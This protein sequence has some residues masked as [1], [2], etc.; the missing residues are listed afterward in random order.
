MFLI[1]TSLMKKSEMHGIVGEIQITPI[2]YLKSSKQKEGIGEYA[3]RE[4]KGLKL[5]WLNF[6]SAYIKNGGNATE[7]YLIAYP[8]VNR[9]TARRNGSRLLSHA[10]IIGEIPFLS[11]D[12]EDL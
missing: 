6:I 1:L 7:A 10:D 11:Q 8:A 12:I 5:Q 9:E 4:G 3:P 2:Y